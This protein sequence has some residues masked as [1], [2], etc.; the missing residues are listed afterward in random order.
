VRLDLVAQPIRRVP[1]K[2]RENEGPG[3]GMDH[4]VMPTEFEIDPRTNDWIVYSTRDPD[5]LQRRQLLTHFVPGAGLRVLVKADAHGMTLTQG[6]I[7]PQV[8]RWTERETQEV[9]L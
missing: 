4:E 2:G 8:A 9:I 6:S 7:V 5:A 1:A 3:F